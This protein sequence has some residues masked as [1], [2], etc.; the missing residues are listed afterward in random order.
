MIM[1]THDIDEA[2]YLSNHLIVLSSRPG[3]IK[4]IFEIELPEPR[5]RNSYEFLEI[6]KKVYEEFFEEATVQE[7]YSI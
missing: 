4:K 1:V 3:K 6:R 7:D 5:N 2:V